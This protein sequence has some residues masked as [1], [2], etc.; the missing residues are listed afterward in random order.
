MLVSYWSHQRRMCDF[1][2]FLED[3]TKLN[4]RAWA[5]PAYLKGAWKDKFLHGIKVTKIKIKQRK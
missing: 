2:I 5:S 1:T 3:G 4:S